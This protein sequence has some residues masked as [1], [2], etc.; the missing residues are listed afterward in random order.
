MVEAAINSKVKRTY[1][2]ARRAGAKGKGSTK[3]F[4]VLNA[5]PEDVIRF[6]NDGIA[7]QR[8]QQQQERPAAGQSSS[9]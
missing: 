5:T 6:I 1:V 4:T 9:G 7:K 2:Q 8:E 3:N